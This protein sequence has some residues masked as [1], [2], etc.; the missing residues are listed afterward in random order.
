MPPALSERSAGDH[1]RADVAATEETLHRIIVSMMML[2][3][4]QRNSRSNSSFYGISRGSIIGM[5]IVYNAADFNR[6]A[7][8]DKALMKGVGPRFIL[9]VAS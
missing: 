8:H 5:K 1:D 2:N 9:P 3:T 6:S 4:A 7:F